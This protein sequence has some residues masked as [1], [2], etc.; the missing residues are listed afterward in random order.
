MKDIKT[1]LFLLIIFF[2]F[3]AGS[4]HSDWVVESKEKGKI[5]VDLDI[6]TMGQDRVFLYSTLYKNVKVIFLETNESCLIG[7]IDK[8]RVDDQ[9]IL[10]LDR[11]IAKRLF[12]FNKEGHFIKNIGNIGHGPGEYVSIDDFTIDRENKTIYILDNSLGRIHKYDLPSGKYMHSIKLSQSVKSHHIAYIKGKLYVD[13]FFYTH[14][15]KDYLLRAIQ[16]SSEIEKNYLNVMEYN[17][18]F[19]NTNSNVQRKTFY[20][21]ENGNLIFVQPFMDRLIEIT[22]DSIHSYIDLKSKNLLTSEEIK[23]YNNSFINMRELMSL[24]KY[25]NIMSFIEKGDLIFMNMMKGRRLHNVL[26]NKK[27]NEFTNFEGHL[28]DLLIRE[29]GNYSMPLPEFGCL[30]DSGAGAYYYTADSEM[31]SEFQT[32]AKIGVLSPGLCG[33]N[34]FENFDE[35]ENPIL[36][37]YEFQE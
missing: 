17:K 28:D 8:M 30:D 9:Y 3:L 26:I 23:K 15:E 6:P 31:A 20:L 7:Q 12:V 16:E 10:I 32:L 11:R 25:F 21:R 24:N 22:N 14:S 36:F 13:A 35:D 19:S 34:D 2:T 5:V 37:Y 33:L 1:I 4:I 27:N 29:S 18:G